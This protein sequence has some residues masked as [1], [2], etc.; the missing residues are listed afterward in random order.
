VK[1]VTQ[2]GMRRK[3]LLI[4]FKRAKE[5]KAVCLKSLNLIN[6]TESKK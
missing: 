3:E 5:M 2:L 1:A 6:C 4:L